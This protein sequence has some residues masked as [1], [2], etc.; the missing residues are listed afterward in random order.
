MSYQSLHGGV[1]QFLK[2]FE[3][4]EAEKQALKEGE[5]IHANFKKA[6]AG[7]E[8]APKD[9]QHLANWRGASLHHKDG[10]SIGVSDAYSHY[11]R[12]TRHHGKE[13][14]TWQ[15]FSNHMAENGYVK[16]HFAGKMRYVGVT[17]G[18]EPY[19][20]NAT[21]SDGEIV[22]GSTDTSDVIDESL[23]GTIG[24]LSFKA[25]LGAHKLYKNYQAQKTK[26]YHTVLYSPDEG[27]TFHYHSHHETAAGADKAHENLENFG[28]HS[29]GDNPTIVHM[30]LTKDEIKQAKANTNHF[31]TSYHA[32]LMNGGKTPTSDQMKKA[33]N[34]GQPEPAPP[35]PSG[36][37]S[38]KMWHQAV[39]NNKKQKEDSD[40]SANPS[41]HYNAYNAFAKKNGHKVMNSD[42]FNKHFAKSELKKTAIAHND[43]KADVSAVNDKTV[44][45]YKIVD[46]KAIPNGTHPVKPVQSSSQVVTTAKKQVKKVNNLA[47]E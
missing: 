35:K 36:A 32:R 18:S 22:D 11:A 23:L 47:A 12:W 40:T 21:R 15:E 14:H 8:L 3:I 16:Q 19:Y 20:E 28:M 30:H 43:S 27:K 1:H 37:K 6:S 46:G 26:T 24:K 41:W 2:Q 44:S 33:E 13:A 39:M 9:S 34:A 17:L 42:E 45:S 5:V 25:A 29:K 10:A 38:F 4:D 31:I 7:E